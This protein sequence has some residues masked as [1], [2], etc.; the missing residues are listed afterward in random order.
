MAP[1]RAGG[2]EA[3]GAGAS[4][5]PS[6]AASSGVH[7]SR[8]ACSPACRRQ[9][10]CSSIPSSARATG[11]TS[12]II[13]RAQLHREVQCVPDT[14]QLGP[15]TPR[16]HAPCSLSRRWCRC[17]CIPRC[18]KRP[19]HHHPTHL[20][21]RRWPPTL[22]PACPPL[23]IHAVQ[24]R[25]LQQ[26]QLEW[27]AHACS[28]WNARWLPSLCRRLRLRSRRSTLP[29]IWHP[30]QLDSRPHAHRLHQTVSSFRPPAACAPLAAP[31][32]LAVA[33]APTAAAA[34]ASSRMTHALPF[35]TAFD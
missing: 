27:V 35:A 33:E 7:Q 23:A 24:P 26:F 9:T 19:R 30:R 5:G 29:R 32:S 6:A 10:G 21:V 17:C 31:A 16:A 15:L 28:S 14:P 3:Y 13:K 8:R 18:D 12:D 20:R 2:E 4:P 1:H 25:P 22:R 11:I 34:A